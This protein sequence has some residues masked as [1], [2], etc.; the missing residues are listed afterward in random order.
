LK[1]ISNENSQIILS[2]KIRLPE[3][4]QSFL[5]LFGYEFNY[6]YVDEKMYKSYYP[7]QKLKIIIAKKIF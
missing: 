1:E 2:F 6:E 3:L 4:T 7:N 5:D